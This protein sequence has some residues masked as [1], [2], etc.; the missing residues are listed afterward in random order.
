[1]V[2]KKNLKRSTKTKIMIFS[3]VTES[4]NHCWYFSALPSTIIYV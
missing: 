2:V 4:S 3:E 1:M